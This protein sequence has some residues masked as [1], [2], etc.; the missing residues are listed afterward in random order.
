MNYYFPGSQHQ[1]IQVNRGREGVKRGSPSS[2]SALFLQLFHRAAPFPSSFF[3]S[4]H[5]EDTEQ[6]VCRR[7]AAGTRCITPASPRLNLAHLVEDQPVPAEPS[8]RAGESDAGD[9]GG[10]RC[11]SAGLARGRPSTTLSMRHFFLLFCFVCLFGNYSGYFFVPGAQRT[12]P[13]RRLKKKKNKTPRS[14]KLDSPEEEET[15]RLELEA[16][17]WVVSWCLFFFFCLRRFSC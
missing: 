1:G 3:L 5:F 13:K 16:R 10:K 8:W 11:S 17:R 15:I 2:T 12:R 14:L 4:P 9:R 6:D 7:S